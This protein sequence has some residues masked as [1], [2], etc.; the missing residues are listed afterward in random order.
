ME[1]V[2]PVI[3]D[4]H[5]RNP[6][7]W[8]CQEQGCFNLKRRPKIEVFA[9]CLPGKIAFSDIDAI[10]EVNGFFLL[11]EWKSYRGDLPI[12]QRIMFERMTSSARFTVLVVV[13]DAETMG[14]EC[15]A[16]IYAGRNRG[17]HSSSLEDVKEH[18]R[19]W[20]MWAKRQR[21]NEVAS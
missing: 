15:A 5:G 20:G 11:L 16:I 13:G 1:G 18:I 19:R 10:S 7:R 2:Y 17:F 14:V 4:I 3:S 12:G 9:E 21:R 8:D 6:L